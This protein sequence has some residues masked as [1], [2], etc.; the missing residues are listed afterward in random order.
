MHK[1]QVLKKV[2]GFSA[3]R[4]FFPSASEKADWLSYFV[5]GK[6]CGGRIKSCSNIVGRNISSNTQ[7]KLKRKCTSYWPQSR[8]L[9]IATDRR[10][11]GWWKGLVR[12]GLSRE[13]RKNANLG[14]RTREVLEKIKGE[15]RR[16]ERKWKEEGK[17]GD[18]N[19]T[20]IIPNAYIY[21]IYKYWITCYEQIFYYHVRYNENVR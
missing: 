5:S 3:S 8:I 19:F 16:R 10:G 6:R 15:F 13:V 9:A 4:L 21:N 7:F 18:E 2:G 12:A 1:A 11:K 20:E 14:L 17:R